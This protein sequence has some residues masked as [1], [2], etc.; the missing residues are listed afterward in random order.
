MKKYFLVFLLLS[1]CSAIPTSGPI[2]S[3]LDIASDAQITTSEDIAQ[4]PRP[5]M[6]QVQVVE[7]FL[8]ANASSVGDYSIARSYL[9]E[10]VASEW[11]PLSGIQVY[12]TALNLRQTT[13]NTVTALGI[14]RLTL[15]ERLRPNFS[16][17]TNRESIIFF[18]TRDNGEWRISNPPS[19][20][21]LPSTQ[22]QR[23][24]EIAPLWFVDKQLSRL[25]PDFIA[26]SQRIDPAIQL[27]RALSNGSSSWLRPAVINLLATEFSGGLV[28]VQRIQDRVVVDLEATVLRLSARE[29]TLMISQI[30]QTLYGLGGISELEITVG[31]QLLAVNGIT[32]PIS[33]KSGVWLAQRNNRQTDVYALSRADE[34]IQLGTRLQVNSW[35]PQYQDTANLTVASDEQRIAV[36]LPRTS[37]IVVGNRTQNPRI[38]SQVSNLTDLN[39]DSNG[40]LW[41]L[42][43]SNG[44]LFNFDG[45][46][47]RLVPSNLTQA[48]NLTHAVVSPDNVRVALINQSATTAVLNLMRLANTNQGA[49]LNDALRILS[50]SGEVISVDWYT[51]TQVALLVKYA[52]QSELVA[53]VVDLATAAQ[54]IVR[55]P[56]GTQKLDANGFG[57]LVAVD[58]QLRI[59]LQSGNSWER[60][61]VGRD[62]TFA[63]Q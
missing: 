14:P 30:A 9:A 17:G 18:L 23:D 26:I 58:S 63:R 59:W 10:F 36:W 29:Q 53:V 7:G 37:E 55:L 44:N 27:I 48:G 41:Y 3:G 47:V 50:I 12:E 31:G 1:G 5:G 42:N 38:L 22:F 28:S 46:E 6:S 52:N 34:L 2:N 13:D 43:T 19:G 35:L 49:S 25:V 54:T 51:A 11:L 8:A 20:L 57:S 16:I 60:I 40:T 32:N 45:A 4:G 61:G 21:I 15:D 56:K 62:A 39:F 33:I 24:Y